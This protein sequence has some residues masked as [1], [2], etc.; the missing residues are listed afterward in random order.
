[1]CGLVNCFGSIYVERSRIEK[2]EFIYNK[3]FGLR[4][5]ALGLVCLSSGPFSSLFFS[6]RS[7]PP[8]WYMWISVW[9]QSG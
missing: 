7:H 8:A 6:S 1:M 3:T 4:I 2:F 5:K 9:P